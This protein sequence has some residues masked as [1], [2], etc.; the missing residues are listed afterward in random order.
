[1]FCIEWGQTMSSSAS[2]EMQVTAASEADAERLLA[3]V[4]CVL[5]EHS[6]PTPRLDIRPGNPSIA[7]TLIF[8]SA[9]ERV[10]EEGRYI[11]WGTAGSRAQCGS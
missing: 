6:L 9:S 11:G 4:W 8:R 3:A 1:M 5:E 7:I 10:L 2:A